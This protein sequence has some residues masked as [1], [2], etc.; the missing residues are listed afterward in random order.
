MSLFFALGLIKGGLFFYASGSFLILPLF[1]FSLFLF[2]GTFSSLF[3]MPWNVFGDA[4][5]IGV[6][7]FSVLLG[8]L[9]GRLFH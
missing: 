2:L 3:F 7:S 4:F 9:F 6:L 1:F 5:F 8:F